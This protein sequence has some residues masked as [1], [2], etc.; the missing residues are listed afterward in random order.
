MTGIYT[1]TFIYTKSLT[2]NIPSSWNVQKDGG[3]LQTYSKGGQKAKEVAP[4]GGTLVL[5]D[6]QMVEHE[7]LA[8]NRE[9]WALVG[10]F[11]ELNQKKRKRKRSE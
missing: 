3:V 7:V 11:L 8:T 4:S 5:F 6:S 2:F 10:W 1:Q 9:R